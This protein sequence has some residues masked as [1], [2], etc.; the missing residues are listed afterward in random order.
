M[1]KSAK[2]L[3]AGFLILFGLPFLGAGLGVLIYAGLC[4]KTYFESSSWER[5][6]AYIESVELKSHT[7]DDGTT[8]SVECRYGYE[9]RG[10]EYHGTR[11]G[12]IGGTSSS[13]ELH[14]KRYDVLKRHMDA[15]ESFPALVDPEDPRRSILFRGEV[16]VWMYALP[17]LGLSF[18][19][20]GLGAG[21]A[22]IVIHRAGRRREMRAREF[23]DKPWLFRDDWRDFRVR[24]SVRMQLVVPWGFVIFGAVFL[25][26]F[27]IL[28]ADEEAFLAK[29][30]LWGL[31]GAIG[32]VFLA[33][34]AVTVRMIVHGR[35]ELVLTELPIVP[36]RRLVAAM[37]TTRRPIDPARVKLTISCQKQVTTRSGR[38][39][40][41]RYEDV[42]REALEVEADSMASE[43]PRTLVPVVFD[44]PAGLPGRGQG[45]FPG[46]YW[47]LE[48]KA[49]SFP[50]SFWASFELPVFQTD[51]S[52]IRKRQ[53]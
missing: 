4:W 35:P 22:G 21:V 30:V 2:Q 11:V 45:F 14:R 53:P 48:V 36:G 13:Y 50:I 16:D 15:E 23:G 32:L 52:E 33:A 39:T 20:V 8:Y 10:R 3:P 43:G 28:F 42:Y 51:E 40:S 25:P 24:A 29:L 18:F 34:V 37:R 6:P 49:R 1:G 9:F 44:I 12:I 27:H 7:G 5:V 31:T 19:L 38:E 26:V 47:S 41:T 46:A 17:F